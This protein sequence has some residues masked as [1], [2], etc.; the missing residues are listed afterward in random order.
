MNSEHAAGT[1]AMR[2]SGGMERKEAN[3][4]AVV[5][6]P[7]GQ[8]MVDFVSDSAC[9]AVRKGAV[10]GEMLSGGQKEEGSVETQMGCAAPRL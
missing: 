5:L 6:G 1:E 3:C 8:K 2:Q 9:S 10:T 4:S 7:G